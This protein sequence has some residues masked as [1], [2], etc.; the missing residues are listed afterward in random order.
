MTGTDRKAGS[1]R[2]AA[3]ADL[4]VLIRAALDMADELGLTAVALR[5]DQALIDLTGEGLAPN[6]EDLSIDEPAPQTGFPSPGTGDGSEIA[7]LS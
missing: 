6:M 2:A 7:Q 3:E 5:L 4:A 1:G